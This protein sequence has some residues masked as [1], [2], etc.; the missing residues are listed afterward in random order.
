MKSIK[1]QRKWKHPELWKQGT[2]TC[3]HC[4]V[5]RGLMAELLGTDENFCGHKSSLNSMCPTHKIHT[6][7]DTSMQTHGE[8]K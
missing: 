5:N 3:F 8:C 7:E 6:C 1:V 4:G 2:G